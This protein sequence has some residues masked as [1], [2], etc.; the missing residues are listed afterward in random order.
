MKSIRLPRLPPSLER[1]SST[2]LNV[3]LFLVLAVLL[4]GDVAGKWQK[5]RFD[6]V[7]ASFAIQSTIALGFILLRRPSQS[8][9]PDLRHQLVA[10]VAFCSAAWF[11]TD[12]RTESASMLIA[13]RVV[14]VTAN[15]LGLA[16][17]VN[18]GR[19]FGIPYVF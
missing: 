16:T 8:V 18:L 12:P 1:H 5:G 17:I 11:S 10:I 19:S 13:A 2:L 6:Y 9:D 3:G 4:V 15:V 14:M 7:E